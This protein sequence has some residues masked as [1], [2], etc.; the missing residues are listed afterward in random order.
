MIIEKSWLKLTSWRILALSDVILNTEKKSCSLRHEAWQYRR[1]LT[2]LEHCGTFYS[3]RRMNSCSL[4]AT[5][6]R[7]PL[8]NV[9]Y[10]GCFTAYR[11]KRIKAVGLVGSGD[12]RDWCWPVLKFI[13][14]CCLCC[15][16][17]VYH[18]AETLLHF[19][20]VKLFFWDGLLFHGLVYNMSRVSFYGYR[21]YL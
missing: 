2:S 16:V 4:R 8:S 18:I 12:S 7:K 6:Y 13:L 15:G 5:I 3:H 19:G 9:L 17:S 14:L 21:A 1:M 10:L 20:S 11:I